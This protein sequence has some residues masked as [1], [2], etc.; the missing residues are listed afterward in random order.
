MDKISIAI[1]FYNTSRY[2]LDCLKHTIDDDFV[3][4][5]VVNDDQSTDEEWETLNKIV[6][7]VNSD[8]IK[9]YKNPINLGGAYES[10]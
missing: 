7:D 10:F 2:F 8:K 1:P 4:E 9:L 5:I 3:S 6:S